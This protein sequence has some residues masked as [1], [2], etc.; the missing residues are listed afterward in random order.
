MTSAKSYTQSINI[1]I[2]I[3]SKYLELGDVANV[4]CLL[5]AFVLLFMII[6]VLP[7]DFEEYAQIVG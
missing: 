2:M 1:C 3:I 7:T 6:S 4:L 5:T